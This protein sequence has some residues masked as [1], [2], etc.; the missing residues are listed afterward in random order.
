MWFAHLYQGV[1]DLGFQRRNERGYQV[2][3]RFTPTDFDYDPLTETYRCPAGQPMW[4]RFKG[5]IGEQETIS[6]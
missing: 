3:Q 2:A 4:K 1:R 5:L 6:F